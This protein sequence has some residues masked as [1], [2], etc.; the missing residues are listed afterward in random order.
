MWWILY[1]AKLRGQLSKNSFI[2]FCAPL[3]S[4]IIMS[5]PAAESVKAEVKADP[6][7]A[8]DKQSVLIRVRL[9][10][11]EQKELVFKSRPSLPL[12]RLMESWSK[13]MGRARESVRFMYDGRPVQDTD[14]AASLSMHDNDTIEVFAEQTGGYYY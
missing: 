10:D 7:A 11:G 13:K 5:A 4:K 9:C 3:K 8:G 6:N 14:T 12:K 1:S 2:A